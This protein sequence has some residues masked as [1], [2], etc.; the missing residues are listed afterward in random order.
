[1]TNNN[2][3]MGGST[4]HRDE[5]QNLISAERVKGTAVYDMAGEKIGSIDSV[6]I[7]KRSGK[8]AYAI[9]SFGGFLGVG[10]K[11]HPLPWDMLDY[12]T[13]L[14][15]YR[16]ATPGEQLK[17]SPAFGR[18]D[19]DMSHTDG[20]GWQSDTDRYYGRAGAM[21]G[22]TGSGLGGNTDRL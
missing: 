20:G 7:A 10:E 5:S 3:T 11:Y 19:L 15:G 16:V 14:G 9:M 1:M 4:I 6:M 12:D 21:N 17:A 2:S 13:D 18:A 22:A 8:V